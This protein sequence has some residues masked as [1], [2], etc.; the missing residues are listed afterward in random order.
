MSVVVVC[1]VGQSE[2]ELT[3]R[4][5]KHLAITRS[6]AGTI[7]APISGLSAEHCGAPVGLDSSTD[8]QQ[9]QPVSFNAPPGA[10]L[11]FLDRRAARVAGRGRYVRSSPT[12]AWWGVVYQAKVSP[13]ASA[14]T[15]AFATTAAATATTAAASAT[16]V[17]ATT[18]MATVT[19]LMAAMGAPKPAT[20]GF[21]LVGTCFDV[22]GLQEADDLVLE[23]LAPLEDAPFDLPRFP[24][25]LELT[26][27][28]RLLGDWDA[29]SPA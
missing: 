25:A 24:T 1:V 22:A 13:P 21:Y 5:G 2:N 4:L 27:A 14:T 8:V 23:K 7:E 3:A 10:D 29:L 15:A 18:P 19:A 28:V 17:A 6:G 16:T 12:S 9:T 26:H 11:D 20:A